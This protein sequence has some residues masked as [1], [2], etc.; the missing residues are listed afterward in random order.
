MSSHAYSGEAAVP[1]DSSWEITDSRTLDFDGVDA[2]DVRIVNG[3]VNVV[4]TDDPTARIEIEVEHGPAL[5]VTH[6]SGGRLVVA[7][8]DLP[9]KGFLKW[10]DRKGWNRKAVVTAR[11]PAGV[12]LNVGV[13]G[14]SAVVSGIRGATAV[15]GVSGH[16]TLAGLTGEVRTDTVS[17]AVEAQGLTGPLRFHSVSGGLTVLSAAGGSIKGDS[18]SGDMIIDVGSWTTRTDV[19][20]NT[21]SGEI[22]LRLPPDTDADV[23]LNSA[24]GKISSA[25]DELGQWG[26]GAAFNWGRMSGRLGSGGGKLRANTVSGA[27]AVLC[28]PPVGDDGPEPAT[29]LRKDV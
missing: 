22:A 21:V 27:V 14:A 12:R 15:Q 23:D 16:T 5:K 10:L 6:K 29:S 2:L 17:G 3:T 13:V 9:W 8:D 20:L 24:G 26:H 19:N 28:R 4:G 7:Y 1:A 18:V 25:F 11:V